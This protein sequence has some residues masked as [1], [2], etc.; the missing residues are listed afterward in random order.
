MLALS[1]IFGL[2]CW[3]GNAWR[4]LDFRK[5]ALL[6]V[7]VGLAAVAAWNFSVILHSATDKTFVWS[8][9]REDA[10]SYGLW[11]FDGQYH[12]RCTVNEEG[13]LKYDLTHT[14]PK[15]TRYLSDQLPTDFEG[16]DEGSGGWPYN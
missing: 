12:Y 9:H 2:G 6:P 10:D 11:Y 16:D 14:V 3:L 7:V 8:G 5:G 15:E 4:E 1:V 13:F